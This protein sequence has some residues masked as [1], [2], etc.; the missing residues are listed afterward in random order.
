MRWSAVRLRAAAASDHVV[1]G[2]NLSFCD[3]VSRAYHAPL[4]AHAQGML[5]D[6][7]ATHLSA[8]SGVLAERSRC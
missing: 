3:L 2:F 4:E 1:P 6:P 7:V 8:R 5:L